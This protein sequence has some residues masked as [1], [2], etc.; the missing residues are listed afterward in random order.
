MD[1]HRRLAAVHSFDLVHVKQ[2]QEGRNLYDRHSDLRGSPDGGRRVCAHRQGGQADRADRRRNP[3]LSL[4]WSGLRR[5]SAGGQGAVTGEWGG[6]RFA[7]PTAW[8]VIAGPIHSGGQ[9]DRSVR[10][11]I[12]LSRLFRSRHTSSITAVT[13]AF[14]PPGRHASWCQMI[15]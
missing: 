7:L 15:L 8:P 10:D 11:G 14:P 13:A 4:R 3:R 9:I 1:G 2:Q 12:G 6:G 5:S